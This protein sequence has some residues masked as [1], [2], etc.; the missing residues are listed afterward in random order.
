MWSWRCRADHS[1]Q[2][3]GIPTAA[4]AAAAT[5]SGQLATTAF[6]HNVVTAATSGVASFNTAPAPVASIGSD[7]TSAGG[8]RRWCRWHGTPTAPTQASGR[9]LDPH[10]YDRLVAAAIAAVTSGR[11]HSASHTRS[12][13]VTLTALDVT[14]SGAT[15]D[16]ALTGTP[17][18]PTAT[19]GT[20]TTQLATTAFVQGAVV[21]AV[22][23]V[24]W[25]GR[26][27][28]TT[29]QRSGFG[30]GRRADRPR[31]LH[32]RAGG[33]TAT[34]GTNTTQLADDRRSSWRVIAGGANVTPFNGRTGAVTLIAGDATGV[35][36]ALLAEPLLHRHP[37]SPTLSA[38]Q[39]TSQLARRHRDCALSASGVASFNTR[40]G[41]VT[42]LLADVT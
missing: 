3:T 41:A 18:A 38:L 11:R 24:T 37:D 17:I 14:N 31:R 19:A 26:T 1:P 10:R 35:G 13:A 33:A 2:F 9:R 16:T 25:N 27:V 4:T 32:R 22:G 6:V 20:S 29:M 5:S 8:A 23:V 28:P 7:I 36:G 15:T 21:G 30:R 34:A 42:L 40:T 12:G 39:D